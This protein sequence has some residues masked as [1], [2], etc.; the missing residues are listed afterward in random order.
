MQEIKVLEETLQT[1]SQIYYIIITDIFLT[2]WKVIF[3]FTELYLDMVGDA[4]PTDTN[5]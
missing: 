5:T 3:D 1:S 2:F 4:H